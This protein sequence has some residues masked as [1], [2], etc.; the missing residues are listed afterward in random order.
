MLI[1]DADDT[2]ERLA[3]EQE[4][5]V[6]GKLHSANVPNFVQE[7]ECEAP[8]FAA[9]LF[10]YLIRSGPAHLRREVCHLGQLFA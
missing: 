2:L 1:P 3:S 6:V 7:E 8:R 4:P 10:A 9:L 5:I